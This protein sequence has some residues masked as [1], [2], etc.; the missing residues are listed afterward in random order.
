MVGSKF[1]NRRWGALRGRQNH[2]LAVSEKRYPSFYSDYASSDAPGAVAPPLWRPTGI[3]IDN[4]VREIFLI[5]EL[6][7][8]WPYW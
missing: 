5:L 3:S 6:L 4:R 2:R 7:F 1:W 8:F